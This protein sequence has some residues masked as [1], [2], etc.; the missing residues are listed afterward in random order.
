MPRVVL[1]LSE[2]ARGVVKVVKARERLKD[3]SEAIE[4]IVAD[5]EERILRPPLRKEFVRELKRIRLGR[6][7][8]VRSLRDVLSVLE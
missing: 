2:H 5:Y 8:K 7:R 6:F 4:H 1:D 3:T